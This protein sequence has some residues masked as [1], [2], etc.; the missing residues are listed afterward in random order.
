MKLLVTG[1]SGRIG[2]AAIER[3]LEE[4]HEV[5]G[6]DEV[7]SSDMRCPFA[8]VDM[9]DYGQ[10]LDAV[11]DIE[12]GIDGIV[13]LAAIVGAKVA[14]GTHIFHT[15]TAISYNVF[16]A[17]RIAG[18]KNIVF[19]SSETL[20]GIPFDDPPAYFPVD[21]KLTSKPES[22]YA[23]SKLVDESVAAEFCRWDPALKMIGLRFSWV[24]EPHQY[25]EMRACED[26]PGVQKWNLWS[27][28]DSRDCA[29]AISLALNASL[30]GFHHFVIAAD[31]TVLALPTRALIAAYYPNVPVQGQLGE[32]GSLVSSQMAREVLGYRPKYSWRDIPAAVS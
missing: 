26:N 24:K 29:Q 19:A 30:N 15:N 23:L 3:L 16:Q 28:V 31:D 14:A 9:R 22:S 13:H 5:I 2:R 27:Y 21:D 6:I 18:I 32:H 1:S 8:R 20:L 12:S 10:V 4:G 7:P 25:D 11:A 17:A